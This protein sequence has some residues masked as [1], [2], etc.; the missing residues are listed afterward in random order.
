MSVPAAYAS[1]FDIEVGLGGAA[2]PARAPRRK[3][4]AP[5]ADTAR[6]KARLEVVAHRGDPDFSRRLVLDPPPTAA[7]CA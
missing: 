2:K 7:G 1:E 3:P 5:P 6:V 4:A